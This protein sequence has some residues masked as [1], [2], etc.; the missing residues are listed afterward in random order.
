M[1]NVKHRLWVGF[2]TDDVPEAETFY[3]LTETGD[4]LVTEDDNNLILENG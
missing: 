4:F 3:L 2:P 1:S